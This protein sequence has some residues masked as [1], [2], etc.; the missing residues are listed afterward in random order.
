MGVK[1]NG[2]LEQIDVVYRIDLECLCL[3]LLLSYQYKDLVQFE[4]SHCVLYAGYIS[5]Q[6]GPV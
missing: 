4:I 6:T 2:H 1:I 3:S 5:H